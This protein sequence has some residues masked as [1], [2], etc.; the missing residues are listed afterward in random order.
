MLFVAVD[1]VDDV[2][3]VDVVVEVVVLVFDLVPC[4][5]GS[6]VCSASCSLKT[7]TYS[8]SSNMFDG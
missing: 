7:R 5:C 1:D 4:S 2:D 6:C 3:A 8:V